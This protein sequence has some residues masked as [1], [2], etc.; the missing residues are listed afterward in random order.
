MP[1]RL[2]SW[3]VLL[4]SFAIISFSYK[5]TTNEW[6]FGYNSRYH[7]PFLKGPYIFYEILGVFAVIVSLVFIIASFRKKW[8]DRIEE[9]VSSK[10]YYP[11]FVIF[12]LVYLIGFLNGVGHVVSISPPTWVVGIV[13]YFGFFLFLIIPFMYFKG[14]SEI[15]RKKNKAKIPKYKLRF[16]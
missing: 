1:K 2:V 16:K 7:I 10:A 6:G 11:S 3:G 8:S 5:P 12:W 9:Y 13:F 4:F 15:T 14:F